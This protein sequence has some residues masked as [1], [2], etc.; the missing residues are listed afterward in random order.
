M[1][2]VLHLGDGDVDKYPGRGLHLVSMQSDQDH[3][4][5]RA[6]AMNGMVPVQ[7]LFVVGWPTWSKPLRMPTE[8]GSPKPVSPR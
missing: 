7:S 8:F 2:L 6:R 1:I 4:Q 5:E 3:D